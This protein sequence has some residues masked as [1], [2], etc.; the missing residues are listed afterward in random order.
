MTP[1]R[2]DPLPLMV[3]ALSVVAFRFVIVPLERFIV[4][5]W[6]VG[7]TIFAVEARTDWYV[8]ALPSVGMR[9]RAR[10]ASS[11]FIKCSIGG[12]RCS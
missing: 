9:R 10:E 8:M 11:F 5:V 1:V 12:F 6:I 3:V 2:P 7:V 4:P